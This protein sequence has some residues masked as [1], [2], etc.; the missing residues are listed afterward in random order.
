MLMAL[1]AL[2]D[3]N[4]RPK[5]DE[6][7]SAIDGNFCRCGAYPNITK[8]TLETSMKL[9]RRKGMIDGEK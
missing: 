7:R 3:K 6:V 8:A 9:L 1:K 5:E 2:L 4:P